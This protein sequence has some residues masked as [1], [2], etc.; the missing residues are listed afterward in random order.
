M[1]E[2]KL[3]SNV[4]LCRFCGDAITGE[5]YERDSEYSTVT[6]CDKQECK[7]ACDE[8]VEELMEAE[9]NDEA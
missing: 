4:L 8:R 2:A 3:N 1:S 6:S 7:E 9:E 5:T